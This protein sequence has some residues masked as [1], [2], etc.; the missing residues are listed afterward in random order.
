MMPRG[1]QSKHG[2]ATVTEFDG[3][4]F[5]EIALQM[6]AEGDEMNHSTA[7]NV[8]LRGLIKMAKPICRL[9]GV[10]DSEIET[11][12][13]RTAVDPRF[14]ASIAELLSSG[15]LKAEE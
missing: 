5:K 8:L 3:L 2:Y 12:S 7:R 4:G 13:I 15:L 11:E 9:H 6:T 14:Q 1:Y 10:P